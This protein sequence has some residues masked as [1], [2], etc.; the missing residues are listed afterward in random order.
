MFVSV[1]FF[2]YPSPA[3]YVWIVPFM[4]IYFI[5]NQNQNKTKILHFVFSFSY[6]VFFIFFYRSE[7]KDILFL[8]QE[9][10][11]KIENEKLRNISFTF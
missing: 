2:V 8:G 11:L 1:L 4:S 9:I 5:Q 6:L 10:D 7:Y 3:W